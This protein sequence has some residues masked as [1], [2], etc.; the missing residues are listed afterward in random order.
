MD[1]K[2]EIRLLQKFNDILS[3]REYEAAYQF[4]ITHNDIQS[5]K[6]LNNFGWFYMNIGTAMMRRRLFII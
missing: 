3:Q 4:I 6:L 1:T 5:M 2:Y